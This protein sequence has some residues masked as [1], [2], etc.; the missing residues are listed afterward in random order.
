MYSL[1]FAHLI[2]EKIPAAEIY[3]LYIDLRCFGK[4][5][6]EFYD[7]AREMGVKFI[8][9]NVSEVVPKGDNLLVKMEDTLLS[10]PF[11]FL[12]KV[13]KLF[14]CRCD[15]RGKQQEGKNNNGGKEKS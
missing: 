9:G 15:R 1:K 13:V 5:Y 10:Q 7:R 3:D 11:C 8:R 12:V 4:G 6:E 2:R 14:R